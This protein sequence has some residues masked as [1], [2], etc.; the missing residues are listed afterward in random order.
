MIASVKFEGNSEVSGKDLKTRMK[1]KPGR[2]F[3]PGNQESDRNLMRK[4]YLKKGYYQVAIR[5]RQKVR[6]DGRLDVVVDVHEGEITRIKRIR[7]IGNKQFSSST[8]RSEIASRQSDFAAWISDRDIYDRKRF[9]ADAQLLQQFYM[10]NGYIDFSVESM[11]LALSN[12]KSG[13]DLTY[14]LHEGNQ[15]QVGDIQ[16]QGDAAP[17]KDTLMELVELKEGQTFSAEAMRHSIEAMTDRVGDEGFAFATVTPLMKR[18]IHAKTVAITFDIEKGKEVYIERVEIAGNEKTEDIVV[19]RLLKQVEG[20]R[21]SASKVKSSK[22]AL[23]RAPYV[24]DVRVSLPKGSSADQVNMKIDVTEKKTG[25]IA[26]GIGFSQQEK[27]TVTA[28][29]SEENAFGKGYRVN[30]NGSIGAITQNYNASLTDPFFMGRNMSASVNAF[31]TEVNPLN[32]TTYT[33]N[34]TGGGLGFG[35]PIAEFWNYGINYQYTTTNLTGILPASSII[36]LSQA[37]KQTT[38]ELTQSLSWD[39]R[40]RTI[41]TSEG[42]LETLA[43]GVA[44]LGGDNQFWAASFSSA[45][46]VPFGEDRDIVF[47]PSIQSGYIRSYGGKKVPL[48]RRFSLGGIG[49]VRGYES[50][51]ISLRDPAT[52]EAIGG[53]KYISAELNLFFP[54]PFMQTDGFRGVVF[55]DAGTVWGSA[56]TTV[57]TASININEPISLSRIRSAAGFGFEWLSPVGPIVMSWGF[58]IRSVAGDIEK[59]FE[60]SLGRSF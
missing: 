25:S 11:V 24:E 17:D 38:G 23:R 12:D 50:S 36:L 32:S 55:L 21:Y 26:G 56:S 44:G 45:L 2:V 22:T 39:T 10:N 7:F 14:S 51:G 30:L 28:K 5:F 43:V 3:S 15:Y 48:Y 13:F 54:M 58:P 19:R 6:A 47:N 52:G 4:G 16:I 27:L 34:S 8:L 53:D 42:H 46:Y 37:G 57:G 18:D 35:I 60:F 20:A 31:K 33:Q 40:D 9:G 41:A 59:T 29:I 1:L 49:T